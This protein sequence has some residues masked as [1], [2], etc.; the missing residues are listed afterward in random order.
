MCVCCYVGN[1]HDQSAERIISIDDVQMTADMKTGRS[2][3]CAITGRSV[4]RPHS[5][6][7]SQSKRS[8]MRRSRRCRPREAAL[9]R[10]NAGLR[11]GREVFISTYIDGLTSSA[12]LGVC[13]RSQSLGKS[14]RR[15]STT[16][17]EISC[18]EFFSQSK[19]TP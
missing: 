15:Q 13:R 18:D 2:L 19:S 8:I 4:G 9:R 5:R 7:S 6:P 12:A 16:V 3:P 10:N 1:K 11:L 17:D 14:Q